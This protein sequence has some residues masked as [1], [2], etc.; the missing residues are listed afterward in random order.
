MK[1]TE[2]LKQL[3]YNSLEVQHHLPKGAV[4]NLYK[5]TLKLQR[6][7]RREKRIAIL[8]LKR[9]SFDL[10]NALILIFSLMKDKHEEQQ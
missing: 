1:C 6:K 10:L 9:G 2:D 5:M 3:L 8:P 7:G 4:N